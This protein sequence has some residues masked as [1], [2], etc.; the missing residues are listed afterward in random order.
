MTVWS[1]SPS[2]QACRH[3]RR[4]LPWGSIPRKLE[5]SSS[6]GSLGLHIDTILEHPAASRPASREDPA[7]KFLLA[8]LPRRW[9]PRSLGL[10]LRT[11]QRHAA[12]V[13]TVVGTAGAL[14]RAS[15]SRACGQP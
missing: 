9:F 7:T 3:D 5:P 13:M 8:S 15:L 10:D 1:A 2:R 4:R 11:R 14:F 6:T 12:E